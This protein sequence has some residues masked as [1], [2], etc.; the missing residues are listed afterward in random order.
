MVSEFVLFSYG[1]YF[2]TQYPVLSEPIR[3]IIPSSCNF[4]R[5]RVTVLRDLLSLSAS[6]SIVIFGLV[7]IKFTVSF[8]VSLTVSAYLK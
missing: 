3:E 2:T 5:V 8:T 6:S 4:L 1:A 7:L